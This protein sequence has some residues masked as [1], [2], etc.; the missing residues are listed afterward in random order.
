M[1]AAAAALCGCT[2]TDDAKCPLASALVDTSSLTE[3]AQGGQPVFT[4]QIHKVDAD[5]D[6]SKTDR[7]V[8]SSLDID[9]TATR[10]DAGSAESFDAPY[11]VAVTLGNRILSKHQYTVH[12]TFDAGQT[13]A[14]FQESQ[15]SPNVHMEKS[16]H[17][18]DYA[19]LVGFQLTHAQLQYNRTAG[20]YP[21]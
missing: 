2:T 13:T 11:F 19:V 16:K 15:D 21:K 6:I 17:P 14:E 1:A 5:C 10:P 18:Y 12:F 7:T 3:L 8:Q 9:F 4:V 20:R